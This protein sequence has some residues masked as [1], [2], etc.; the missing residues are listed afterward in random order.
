[1]LED[2]K[3]LW[4]VKLLLEFYELIAG[5]LGEAAVPLWGF[6]R[7]HVDLCVVWACGS[8]VTWEVRVKYEVVLTEQRLEVGSDNL[9]E[10]AVWV[11]LDGCGVTSMRGW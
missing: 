4:V 9:R 3:L 11:Y 2:T 10:N 5:I 8:I 6:D 1:M 7:A